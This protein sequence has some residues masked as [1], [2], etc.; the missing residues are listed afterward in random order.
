MC[1]RQDVI[2]KKETIEVFQAER[3]QRRELVTIGIEELRNSTANGG[4]R[5]NLEISTSGKLPSPF[6][7]GATQGGHRRRGEKS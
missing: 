4:Q 1:I 3:I 6:E 2:R 5:S 7:R